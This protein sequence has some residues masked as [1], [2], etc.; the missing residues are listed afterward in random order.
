MAALAFRIA[1]TIPQPSMSLNRLDHCQVAARSYAATLHELH[2]ELT[3]AP[4]ARLKAAIM[5]ECAVAQLSRN[6]YPIIGTAPFVSN[7]FIVAPSPTSRRNP[8]ASTRGIVPVPVRPP[9]Q[10][11]PLARQSV[12][13][14]KDIDFPRHPFRAYPGR[15][16]CARSRRLVQAQ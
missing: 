4:L 3:F 11:T 2:Q 9:L 6:V 5:C 7:S 14:T 10:N 1:P 16:S 8:A 13:L 12:Y 15:W